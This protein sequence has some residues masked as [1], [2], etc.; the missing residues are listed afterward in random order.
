MNIPNETPISWAC[1]FVDTKC[2]KYGKEMAL[3]NASHYD[4]RDYCGMC[5][6]L[7][8]LLDD[9]F[10]GLKTLKEL[11]CKIKEPRGEKWQIP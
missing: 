5:F 7:R 10:K 2:Y 11:D 6:P 9:I 4:G 1:L 8:D 3:S